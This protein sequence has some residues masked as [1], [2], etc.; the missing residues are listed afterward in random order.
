MISYWQA[1]GL[2]VIQG[3]TEFIPVSST[4]HLRIVPAFLGWGDPG[5][6]Y[7]AVIQLGTLIALLIFF[8]K[9]IWQ[10][11]SAALAGLAS[12]K[13]FEH[14]DAR[15][16]WFMVLGTVPVSVLGLTFSRWITGP[17][18]SL[19]VIA[20]S[21]IVLAVLLYAADLI[22]KRTKEVESSTWRDWLWVGLAQSLALIPGASRSGTTLTMGLLLG[23]TREAS[24]RI[25][26]L[27]SIPAIGL[28]GGYELIKERHELASLGFGGLIVGTLTAGIV[29]YA[30][31]AFLLQFLRKHSVLVFSLYRAALGLTLLVLLYQGI[32]RALP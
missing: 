24:M 7:S 5:A 26:F 27:L 3:L 20:G 11:T 28:S 21:L 14:R 12:G 30:T 9:D 10:F 2:G 23:F 18:R 31:I 1:I 32:L 25:S 17:A 19:Y 22:S 6:A 4:A 29:G 15:M 13:P 16:A 8:R